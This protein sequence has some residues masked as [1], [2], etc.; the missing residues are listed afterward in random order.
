ME[1]RNKDV[2]HL[3]IVTGSDEDVGGIIYSAGR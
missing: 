1:I 3:E 2:G